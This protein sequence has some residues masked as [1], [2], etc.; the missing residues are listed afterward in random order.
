VTLYRIFVQ[1]VDT[2]LRKWNRN[3][4]VAEAE[5]TVDIVKLW[6]ISW[7]ISWT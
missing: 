7:S 2:A 5:C 4:K 6:D 3:S 1:C